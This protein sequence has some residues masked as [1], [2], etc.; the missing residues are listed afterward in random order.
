VITAESFS[1][2]FPLSAVLPVLSRTGTRRA[3]TEP[4]AFTVLS[5]SESRISSAKSEE[6]SCHSDALPVSVASFCASSSTIV[7][8]LP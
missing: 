3:R 5:V 8:A 4:S 1:P 2:G 6:F 7:S